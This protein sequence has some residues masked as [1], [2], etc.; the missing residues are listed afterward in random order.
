MSERT[1]TPA[2]RDRL[3]ELF[4]PENHA[5][6]SVL[7]RE[8]LDRIARVIMG[9]ENVIRETSWNRDPAQELTEFDVYLKENFYNR[10]YFQYGRVFDLCRVLGIAN[11]YNIGCGSVNQSFLLMRYSTMSY[12]GIMNADFDLNDFRQKD[13]EEKNAFGYISPDAPPPFAGGRISF[14]KGHYPD[15]RPEIRGN[16]IA[17]C[18]YSIT[19]CRTE[20]SI[21]EMVNA[22]TRDFERVL[23]NVPY[24]MPELAELWKKQNWDGYTIC[25]VGPEGYVLATRHAEDTDR[26]KAVYPHENGRFVTGIDDHQ[27]HLSIRR[28]ME[29]EPYRDYAD[30]CTLKE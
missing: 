20:E 14:I 27:Q 6:R 10:I 26:M 16:N 13:F 3:T 9:S 18:C 8:Q 15:I 12:T 17:V 19:M 28:R 2:E 11:L 30:W 4:L 25:P 23:F 7:K 21:S 5:E 29:W 1:Y 24:T 22:L